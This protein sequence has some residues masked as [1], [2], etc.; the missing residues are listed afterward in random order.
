MHDVPHSKAG[1]E[2]EVPIR[3]HYTF[4][5]ASLEVYVSR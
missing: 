4:V 1:A 3:I 2:F 5:N